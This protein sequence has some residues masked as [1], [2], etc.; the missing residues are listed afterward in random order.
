MP[1]A[2]KIQLALEPNKIC[3]SGGTKCS[4]G[5]HKNSTLICENSRLS[6]FLSWHFLCCKPPERCCCVMLVKLSRCYVLLRFAAWVLCLKAIGSKCT[7]FL[8]AGKSYISK[9]HHQNIV[10]CIKSCTGKTEQKNFLAFCVC[11]IRQ[12]ESM[13]RKESVFA[14]GFVVFDLGE[15]SAGGNA[16]LKALFGIRLLFSKWTSLFFCQDAG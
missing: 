1:G 3:C 16:G 5:S 10:S 9:I 7:F 11:R 8:F 15:G 4:R 13:N 14:F 2:P 6:A 12:F